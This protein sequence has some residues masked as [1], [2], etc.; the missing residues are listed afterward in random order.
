MFSNGEWKIVEEEVRTKRGVVIRHEMQVVGTI[1][2]FW[3]AS[4]PLGFLRLDSGALL[5]TE[6]G[7]TPG[8][9]TLPAVVDLLTRRHRFVVY[10]EAARHLDEFIEF[11]EGNK[12]G[13]TGGGSDLLN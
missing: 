12:D 11:A 1:E 13:D 9:E 10:E 7:E 3:V 5:V 8:T 4:T 2:S 6:P